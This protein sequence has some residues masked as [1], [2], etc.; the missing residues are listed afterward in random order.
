[1]CL[2]TIYSFVVAT[3]EGLVSKVLWLYIYIYFS[4]LM[5]SVINLEK[6]SIVL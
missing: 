6:Y 4:L 5:I 1:M 2:K 3:D